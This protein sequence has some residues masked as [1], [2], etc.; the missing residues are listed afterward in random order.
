MPWAFLSC[1]RPDKERTGRMSSMQNTSRSKYAL[2][3]LFLCGTGLAAGAPAATRDAAGWDMARAQLVAQQ[4]T[5][6]GLAINRWEDLNA[7]EEL[8]FTAYSGFL[9]AF[10]AR[11]A[12]ANTG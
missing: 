9:L 3:A 1:S 4:P 7:N 11:C 10:P 5:R 12:A 2:A 8:G 6:I